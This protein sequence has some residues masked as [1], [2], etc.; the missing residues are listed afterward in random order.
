MSV[1]V[2]G[3]HD[4]RL[5]RIALDARQA[6]RTAIPSRYQAKNSSV[7][8]MNVA[9]GV[10]QHHRHDRADAG[11]LLPALCEADHQ[12]E[13]RQQRIDHVRRRIAHAIGGQHDVGRDSQLQEQRHEHR[14]EDRPLRQDVRHGNAHQEADH[15]KRQ[16]QRDA[17]Q[18]R[19]L[20]HV[21]QL[22]GQHRPDVA[23]S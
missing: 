13:V 8:A 3:G 15:E 12:R 20:E 5:A 23:V 10:G 18:I 4:L 1:S 17:V 6:A 22:H 11:V 21:G 9:D 2:V 16:Q 19:V 14:R 7:Q